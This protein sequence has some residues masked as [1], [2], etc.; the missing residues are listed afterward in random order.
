LFPGSDGGLSRAIN[1]LPLNLG[2]NSLEERTRQEDR[3][4][5]IHNS[6][7]ITTTVRL[8]GFLRLSSEIEIKHRTLRDR[9]AENDNRPF[10]SFLLSNL[11]FGWQRGWN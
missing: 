3:Q 2:L 9:V 4:S 6:R 7:G 8:A 5:E 11:A 10:Y 1:T